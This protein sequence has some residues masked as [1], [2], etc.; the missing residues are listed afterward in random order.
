MLTLLGALQLVGP[1]SALFYRKVAEVRRPVAAEQLTG[2][3]KL[4][5]KGRWLP[6]VIESL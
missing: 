1:N 5:W 4:L 2:C 6:A 3:L